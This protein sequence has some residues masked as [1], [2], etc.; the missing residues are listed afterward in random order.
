MANYEN[1]LVDNLNA[2]WAN[3]QFRCRCTFERNE[4]EVVEGRL[5]A[6]PSHL[7]DRGH[8]KRKHALG[9]I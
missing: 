2:K 5:Q 1:L 4:G 7:A 6:A 9:S 3:A 8:S